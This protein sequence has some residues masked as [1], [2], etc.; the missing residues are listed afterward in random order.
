[1][2]K[3]IDRNYLINQ[4]VLKSRELNGEDNAYFYDEGEA[5][6]FLS[7]VL[8]CFNDLGYEIIQKIDIDFFK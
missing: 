4:L 7:L 8:K 2:S 5:K 6:V 3:I 1:M